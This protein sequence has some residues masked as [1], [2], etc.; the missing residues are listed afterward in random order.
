MEKKLKVALI[1]HD[2]KK[3][4]LVKFIKDNE[5]LFMTFDLVAT[6]MTGMKIAKKTALNIECFD[7]G[8]RGG[9]QEIGLLIAKNEVDAVFFFRD[10]LTAKAS[11]PD[12]NTIPRLCDIYNTPFAT[13]RKSA[14]GILTYLEEKNLNARLPHSVEP[15]FMTENLV[16]EN[17]ETEEKIIQMNEIGN[18]MERVEQNIFDQEDPLTR[19]AI[20]YIYETQ[21]ASALLLQLKFKLTSARAIKIIKDM[22]ARG[23]IGVMEGNKPRQVLMTNED[24]QEAI[25]TM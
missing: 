12:A 4:D 11:E 1:A 5:S 21:K 14:M 20:A 8:S 16:M 15:V 23:L 7:S 25:S 13:N 18:L 24:Y 9:D 2:R 17:T 10:L 19:E 6:R 22:E 3:D